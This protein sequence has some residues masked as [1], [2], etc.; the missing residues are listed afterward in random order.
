MRLVPRNVF[1]MGK[2]K[3][4]KEQQDDWYK[5]NAPY[6][7]ELGYPDCCIK[8]FCAQPPAL[9]AK[10]KP[11]KDDKRRYKAACINGEYSGFIPCAFHAKEI[12]TKKITLVSLIT[13][14][15]EDFL[16]F[17]LQGKL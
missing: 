3:S 12:T 6:G 7:K 14:R 4:I 11:S 8:A 9:L 5:E 2:M 13:N 1:I 16:P 17:P 10:K 15:N